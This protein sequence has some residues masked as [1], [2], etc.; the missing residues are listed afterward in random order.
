MAVW[1]LTF[2][3]GGAAVLQGG[4]NRHV[5][6]AWGLSGAIL[7][8]TV[9]LFSIALIFAAVAHY[10]PQLV[11]EGSSLKANDFK[12]WF[13]IPGMCGFL[14]VAMI[15]LA[16]PKIGASGVFLSIVVGQLFFSLLWDIKVEQIAI[17]PQRVVGILLAL[18]GV[19]L[20]F[21]S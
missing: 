21:R 11:P 4:L 2:L 13:V 9:V 16:I 10:Y 18:V 19:V 3:L 14:L 7:F 6:G 15:P 1:I 8:N 17:E 20:S 5:M 12:W